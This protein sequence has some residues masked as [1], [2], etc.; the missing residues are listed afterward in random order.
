[1]PKTTSKPQK[2]TIERVQEDQEVQEVQEDQKPALFE[3]FQGKK[4]HFLG[5]KANEEGVVPCHAYSIAGITFP[6]YT[7]VPIST[8]GSSLPGRPVKTKGTVWL[9]LSNAEAGDFLEL[10]QAQVGRVL[11]HAT[12]YCVKWN[13]GYDEDQD[14]DVIRRASIVNLLQKN[15]APHPERVGTW[16]ETGYMH[17]ANEGDDPLAKYLVLLPADKMSEY[18][19]RQ[20]IDTLPSLADLF[21]EMLKGPKRD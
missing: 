13:R 4:K 19:D 11:E 17:E 2:K 9:A 6:V 12:H 14:K 7:Q 16:V 10:T 1:M 18:G 21:P 5:I 8:D 15:L 20:D 3:K